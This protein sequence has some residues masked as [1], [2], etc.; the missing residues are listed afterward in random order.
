MFSRGVETEYLREIGSAF[1]SVESLC[2]LYVADWHFLITKYDFD[3]V[4][5]INS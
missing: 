3:T 5:V 2:I 1:L 4:V